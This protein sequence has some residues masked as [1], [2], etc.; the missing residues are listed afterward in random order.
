VQ[1]QAHVATRVVVS[2]FGGSARRSTT[3]ASAR[4]TP[5]P[6]HQVRP[7][8]ASPAACAVAEQRQRHRRNRQWVHFCPRGRS[9]PPPPLLSWGRSSHTAVGW[10]RAV[11]CSG[12]AATLAPASATVRCRRAPQLLTRPPRTATEAL[13]RR[14]RRPR[15]RLRTRVMATTMRGSVPLH[16][17][18]APPH[19]A[20]APQP[21]AR[22]RRTLSRRG[23]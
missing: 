4:S 14:R 18:P 22:R 13:R 19:A 3:T 21:T 20:A 2:A 17:S 1:Q 8:T 23:G 11:A 10:R 5:P 7:L 15:R 6:F 9:P 12:L 16:L